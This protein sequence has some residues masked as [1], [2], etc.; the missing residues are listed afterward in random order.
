VDFQGFRRKLVAISGPWGRID[1]VAGARR[2]AEEHEDECGKG[3]GF[4]GRIDAADYSVG[5]WL[6]L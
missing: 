3:P 6:V 2:I 1:R 5:V 4:D